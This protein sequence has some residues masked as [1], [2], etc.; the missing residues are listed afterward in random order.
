MQTSHSSAVG[1]E[2]YPPGSD[3]LNPG[4]DKFMAGSDSCAG[5]S[6]TGAT[7]SDNGAVMQCSSSTVHSEG[8]E[9]LGLLYQE[10]CDQ[11]DVIMACLEEDKCDI[12]QVKNFIIK[13][14]W[15]QLQ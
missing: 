13:P 1:S 10:I 14:A 12:E 9:S 11:K 6:S 5:E 8:T 3:R 7:G 2:S 4:S 15:S